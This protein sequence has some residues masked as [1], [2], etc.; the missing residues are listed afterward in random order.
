MDTL[1]ERHMNALE[2]QAA[3]LLRQLEC[4]MEL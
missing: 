2:E 3:E 1:E 4:K